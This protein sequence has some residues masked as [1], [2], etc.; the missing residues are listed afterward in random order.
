MLTGLLARALVLG[1]TTDITGNG[2]LGTE[3]LDLDT[4]RTRHDAIARPWIIWR[5]RRGRLC[6][7]SKEG[8][9]ICACKPLPGACGRQVNPRL[10]NRG[11]QWEGAKWHLQMLQGLNPEHFGLAPRHWS[12]TR[13]TLRAGFLFLRGGC[14][15]AGAPSAGRL[16]LD[17]GFPAGSWAWSSSSDSS[18]SLPSSE[19]LASSSTSSSSSSSS[20]WMGSDKKPGGWWCAPSDIATSEHEW[21][22]VKARLGTRLDGCQDWSR[23]R[24]G[25]IELKFGGNFASGS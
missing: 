9:V 2:L 19:S 10:D 13:T 6:T 1:D 5:R 8:S 22:R 15:C 17:D 24:F 25:G 16:P 18:S 23:S 11:G 14:G 21:R 4:S 12:Q 7:P 20:S 3:T